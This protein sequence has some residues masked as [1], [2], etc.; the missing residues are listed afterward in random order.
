MARYDPAENDVVVPSTPQF[1]V[2]TQQL[3]EPPPNF[4]Q[5]VEQ[6]FHFLSSR[7]NYWTIRC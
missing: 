7:P 2:F 6:V 4:Y 1:L 3:T 5:H